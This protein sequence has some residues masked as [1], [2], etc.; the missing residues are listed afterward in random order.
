MNPTEIEKSA[1][2]LFENVIRHR[3][4]L[5]HLRELERFAKDPGLTLGVKMPLREA[6]SS[7]L[8][9]TLAQRA[10]TVESRPN[11]VSREAIVDGLGESPL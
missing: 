7:L 5:R 4:L 9:A 6:L 10:H 2:A 8:A 3:E 1:G 11:G